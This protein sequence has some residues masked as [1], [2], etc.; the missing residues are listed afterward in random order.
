MAATDSFV[1]LHLHTEY[2]LLDGAVKIKDLMK[3]VV[4]QKMP[5]VAM[6]DH[7]NMFGA[8]EFYQAAHAAGVKPIIGCEVY[9]QPPPE[10]DKK[11]VTKGKISTHLTLLCEN[12]TGYANLMKLV[13]RGHLDG[14]YYGKPLVT[15]QD[16]AD[17]S[18]GL[19]CLSGC[20]S[21]EINLFLQNDQPD[22]ARESLKEF[23]EI[24]GREHFYLEIH[25][26]GLEV[27][28]KCRD[29]LLEFAVDEDLKVVAA[30]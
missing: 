10:Y 19:I 15:K 28:K 6:T 21:G 22:K 12:N 16:L 20:I 27:Q 24:Y 30:N 11:K 23:L 2:S 8:I 17:C 5:A 4:K 1:H 29:G 9:L 13:T 25:D 3:K 14:Q 7:G 26:H 18:E